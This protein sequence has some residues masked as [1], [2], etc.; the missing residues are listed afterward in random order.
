[1]LCAV[2][3]IAVC[4]TGYLCQIHSDGPEKIRFLKNE[5]EEKISQGI[6]LKD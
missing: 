5:P 3:Q 1:M 6:K 4:L 2:W